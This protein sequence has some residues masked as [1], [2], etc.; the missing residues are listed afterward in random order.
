VKPQAGE[1]QTIESNESTAMHRGCSFKVCPAW[2]FGLHGL[3]RSDIFNKPAYDR[4]AAEKGDSRI[5]DACSLLLRLVQPLRPY[6]WDA[7]SLIQSALSLQLVLT[8]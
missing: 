3:N 6:Q 5:S 8:G 2:E 1:S 4:D 7:L